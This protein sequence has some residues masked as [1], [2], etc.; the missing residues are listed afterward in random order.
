MGH[1]WQR[2]NKFNTHLD[3]HLGSLFFLGRDNT[4]T[5]LTGRILR[6]ASRATC[7]LWFSPAQWSEK[8]L[9]LDYVDVLSGR[10]ATVC[11]WGI[12]STWRMT[13]LVVIGLKHQHLIGK[14]RG[15]HHW[16]YQFTSVKREREKERKRERER[17]RSQ[18]SHQ[19]FG[20][21]GD[22]DPACRRRKSFSTW[23]RSSRHWRFW[24]GNPWE[25]QD[26]DRM[27]LRQVLRGATLLAVTCNHLQTIVV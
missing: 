8:G 14:P 23:E 3:F 11:T 26:L 25:I 24:F 20:A 6:A 4:H 18:N 5:L 2:L 19:N 13:F 27:I 22:G 21:S 17:L 9:E 12:L 15:G 7:R 16:T 1:H 10:S